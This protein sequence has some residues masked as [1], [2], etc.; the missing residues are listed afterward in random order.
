MSL[1]CKYIDPFPLV[2]SLLP[3]N[4]EILISSLKRLVIYIKKSII[5]ETRRL[6]RELI[7]LVFYP[8]FLISGL[9]DNTRY[10]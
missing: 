1:G 5:P 8:W 2:C 9:G 7:C 3:L 10:S 4:K 6:I